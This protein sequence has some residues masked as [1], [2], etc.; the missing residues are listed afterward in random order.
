MNDWPLVR[1]KSSFMYIRLMHTIQSVA[2]IP[3]SH[4]TIYYQI[5]TLYLMARYVKYTIKYIILD[6]PVR[7]LTIVIICVRKRIDKSDI[8]DIKY[9]ASAKK[10]NKSNYNFNY[11]NMFIP[12]I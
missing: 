12:K 10:K 8:S 2:Y 3:N 5:K 1:V 11:L 7:D 9:S 4:M 6:L